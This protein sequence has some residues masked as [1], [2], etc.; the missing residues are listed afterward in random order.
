MIYAS[1]RARPC[2]CQQFEATFRSSEA[3]REILN[4]VLHIASLGK[5]KRKIVFC[6]NRIRTLVSMTIYSFYL[7]MG[8]V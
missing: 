8:K 5:G 2:V 6:Y 7:K 4:H 3:V 1:V